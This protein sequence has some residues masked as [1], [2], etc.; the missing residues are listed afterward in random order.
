MNGLLHLLLLYYCS[1]RPALILLRSRFR[2]IRFISP[3]LALLAH[4]LLLLKPPYY[5]ILLSAPAVLL[6]EPQSLS[7]LRVLQHQLYVSQICVLLFLLP[8]L[9]R[10]LLPLLLPKQLFINI[11][12]I[13]KTHN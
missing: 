6:L 7:P 8:T 5:M 2:L 11:H 10:L 1:F 13:Y 4:N 9:L 12:P 3:L